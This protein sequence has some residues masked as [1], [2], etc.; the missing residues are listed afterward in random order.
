MNDVWGWTDPDGTVR[1]AGFGFYQN[2]P[3][4][5]REQINADLSYFVDDF[6][7]SHEFKAGYEF[8]DIGGQ[9]FY[10]G[11]GCKRCV[12]VPTT[13]KTLLPGTGHTYHGT[14]REILGVDLIV[15]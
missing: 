7:G 15:T 3:E 10:Y 11:K 5:T 6:G 4:L 14:S 1:E 2:Q 9:K 8:E 12:N 13:W